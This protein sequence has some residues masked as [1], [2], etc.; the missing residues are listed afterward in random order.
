M[1]RLVVV[2]AVLVAATGAVAGEPLF[3]AVRAGD[4]ANIERL[5]ANGAEVDRRARDMATPLTAAALAD[6]PAVAK[7][8]LARGADVMARNSGGFT[9]LH[10]AA[11]SG[12]VSVAELLLDKGAVLDDA[13]NKAGAA[14]LMLAVEENHVAMLELLIARGAD[15]SKPEIHKYTPLMRAVFKGHKDIVRVLKRHGQACPT[16]ETLG[17]VEYGGEEY[18]RLC[19]EVQK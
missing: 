13:A 18:Y 15:V 4:T 12:S 9:P 8:L 6:Q 11:Y 16:I 1:L 17:G 7:L 10:A 3:D 2:L 5:L 19:I 14:P